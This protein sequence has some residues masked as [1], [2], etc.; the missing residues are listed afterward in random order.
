MFYVTTFGPPRTSHCRRCQVALLSRTKTINPFGFIVF[1]RLPRIEL[2]S[3]PWQGVVIPL[4]YSRNIAYIINVLRDRIISY[5]AQSA[6][7]LSF[8]SPGH[9]FADSS[10]LWIALANPFEPSPILTKH[11]RPKLHVFVSFSLFCGRERT[12]TLHVQYTFRI[13]SSRHGGTRKYAQGLRVLSREPSSWLATPTK[14]TA[15]VCAF[16]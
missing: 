2:G 14:L 3:T 9:V 16:I 7:N 13:F 11:S 15:F 4:N 1:V 12:R 6:K 8:L 10:L 5:S